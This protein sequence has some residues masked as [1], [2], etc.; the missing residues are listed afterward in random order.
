[1]FMPVM[2]LNFETKLYV[3]NLF[4]L[5]LLIFTACLC[6]TQAPRPGRRCRQSGGAEYRS[7]EAAAVKCRG[8]PPFSSFQ[9]M[10]PKYF[11]QLLVKPI[12]QGLSVLYLFPYQALTLVFH[13]NQ[14]SVKFEPYEAMHI[15]QLF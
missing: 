8:R 14:Q 6:S 3:Y 9:E 11:T 2:S 5:Q 13:I 12:P 1:M 15:M 7:L 10:E 4:L